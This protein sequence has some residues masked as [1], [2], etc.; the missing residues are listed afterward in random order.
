M[1]SRRVSCLLEANKKGLRLRYDPPGSSNRCYYRCLS[2]FLNLRE[3]D[4][5]NMLEMVMI[6]NQVIPVENVGVKYIE[7]TT[8]YFTFF[9]ATVCMF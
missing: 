9:T 8:F 5:I 6:E 7:Y 4:L 2:K 3:D 1:I